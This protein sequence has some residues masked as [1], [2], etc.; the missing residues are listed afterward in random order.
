MGST[1]DVE[2]SSALYEHIE[3]ITSVKMQRSYAKLFQYSLP[4]ITFQA[5]LLIKDLCKRA[6]Y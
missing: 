4:A 6:K 5:L 3:Q 2:T 1:Y